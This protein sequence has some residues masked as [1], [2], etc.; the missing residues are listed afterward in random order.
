MLYHRSVTDDG[1]CMRARSQRKKERGEPMCVHDQKSRQRKRVFAHAFMLPET[2]CDRYCRLQ[3]LAAVSEDGEAFCGEV[4]QSRYSESGWEVWEAFRAYCA[5]LGLRSGVDEVWY[6]ESVNEAF[7]EPVA[8]C[9]DC[10]YEHCFVLSDN[11]EYLAR[12]ELRRM[13]WGY[14]EKCVHL[15]APVPLEELKASCGYDAANEPYAGRDLYR[16]YREVIDKDTFSE[17][18]CLRMAKYVEDNRQFAATVSETSGAMIEALVRL[19]KSAPALYAK[20]HAMLLRDF[21]NASEDEQEALC[22]FFDWLDDEERDRCLENVQPVP[23]QDAPAWEGKIEAL[24]RAE[25][26][27][28]G[29]EQCAAYLSDAIETEQKAEAAL[30]E[31]RKQAL[32]ELR[33]KYAVEAPVCGPMYMT[34]DGALIDCTSFPNG[35]ADISVWL[36]ERGLEID[37]EPGKPS[38]LLQYMGWV[39]LNIKVGYADYDAFVPTPQQ[40]QRLAEIFEGGKDDGTRKN[41]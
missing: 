39:R 22:D 9:A 33:Q 5:K 19:K 11:M 4:D 2:V 15:A 41:G 36:N 8:P 24:R 23:A 7:D 14:G 29:I 1:A 27:G 12:W 35:H 32:E 25:E 3:Y 38:M 34:Q 28:V 18:E 16:K 40:K 17:E 20:C 13:Q 30:W 31:R 10:K 6:S 21:K 37:H 26:R